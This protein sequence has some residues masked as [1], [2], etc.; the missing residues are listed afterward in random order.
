MRIVSGIAKGRKILSPLAQDVR[1]TK[2]RVRE[3]IFN[4]LKSF[5]LIDGRHFVDLFAGSGALGI[6]ALSRG[7]ERVTFVDHQKACIDIIRTNVENLGFGELAEVRHADYLQELQ[8]VSK[9]DVVLLDPPYDFGDWELLLGSIKSETVV[10]ESNQ[11]IVLSGEWKQIKS[12]R[13]GS[14]FVVIAVQ[15]ELEDL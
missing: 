14:T 5:E 11:E 4:S 8:N 12:K 2:D 1:P 10:I 3:A 15:V 13:Y 9:G 6:E 7:A